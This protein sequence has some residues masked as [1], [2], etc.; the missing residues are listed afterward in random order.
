MDIGFRQVR[1]RYEGN[2][3]RIEVSPEERVKFFDVD[4]LDK[5]GKKFKE[6]GFAYSTMDLL[7]YRTGSMNE[8][9]EKIKK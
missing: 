4:L 6:I 9:I 2:T 8:V 5:V 3:A 1:V 7:G